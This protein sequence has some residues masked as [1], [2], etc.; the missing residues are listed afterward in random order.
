MFNYNYSYGIKLNY[1]SI[2][3]IVS[4]TF[5]GDLTKHIF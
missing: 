5:I 3:N 4:K 1:N 2:H